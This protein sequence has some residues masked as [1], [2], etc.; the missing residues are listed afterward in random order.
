MKR[1]LFKIY[2]EIRKQLDKVDKRPENIKPYQER[3]TNINYAHEM[4]F[5][6]ICCYGSHVECPPKVHSSSLG[7][8]GGVFRQC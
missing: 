5:N 3:Y 4:M 1:Q 7:F 6:I 8:P 2:K